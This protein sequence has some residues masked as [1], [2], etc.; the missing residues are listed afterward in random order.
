[1]AEFVKEY[2]HDKAYLFYAGTDFK[3]SSSNVK[4]TNIWFGEV[5][6]LFNTA[7]IARLGLR[8]AVAVVVEHGRITEPEIIINVYNIKYFFIFILMT[9]NM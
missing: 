5:A 4:Y 2:Q 3:N 9:W 7:V 1:M 8:T 6:D